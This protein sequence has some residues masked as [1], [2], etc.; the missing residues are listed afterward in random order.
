MTTPG[1]YT[2]SLSSY[3]NQIADSA[4]RQA[5]VAAL[6]G[7]IRPGSVVLDLG[8]GTGFFALLAC[9][10]GAA[11]VY[12]I[13]P[14]EA[15]LVARELAAH[16]GL[17]QRI[18]FI[19][20]VSSRV[21]LPERVDVI[22]ADLRGI[23]PLFQHHL[24]TLADARRRFLAEG[25]VL[26][27]RRDELWASVAE[28]PELYGP[29]TDVWQEGYEGIDLRP[30]CRL[31]TSSW[32]R[33]HLTPGHLLAGPR[34]WIT[35]DYWSESGTD[36]T[37]ELTWTVE[38]PGTAHGLAVWFDAELA[39]GVSFSTSPVAPR[40][41]Y[42]QAFFPL[43]GP[44]RVEPGDSVAAQLDARLVGDDYVWSWATTVRSAGCVKA[45]Y[46]QS[47]FLSVPL[48]PA[49]LRYRA[50]DHVPTLDDEGRIDGLVLSLMDG[51]RSLEQIAHQVAQAFPQ[52]F[53]TWQ[54][55]LSRVG[56]LS[57]RY[58]RR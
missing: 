33:A 14:A 19:Q 5:S 20:D 56:D 25:G 26:I 2:Y 18:V 45:A 10:L 6:R 12:A 11:R 9:R 40:T 38:R 39:A 17:A 41:I 24:E 28:A 21:E 29:L 16:N 44:V 53:P 54:D 55:A 23:L 46:R 8:A 35:L 36:F 7:A 30:A 57:Q 31:A 42:G 3:G 43:D 50:A 37:S 48:S 22:I 1:P 32:F 13:E 52:A 4:R 27:P 15:I 47:S 51:R 49:A 58:T 34:R